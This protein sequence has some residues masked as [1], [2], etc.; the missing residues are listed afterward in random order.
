LEAR[1]QKLRDQEKELLA[2]KE[3]VFTKWQEFLEKNEEL[4]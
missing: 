1:E 4:Q 3:K 2:Q